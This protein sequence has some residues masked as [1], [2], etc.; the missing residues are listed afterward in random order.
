MHV[1]VCHRILQTTSHNLITFNS[2]K[3]QSSAN[4]RNMASK[5]IKLSDIF[6]SVHS[7]SVTL[8]LPLTTMVKY[9]SSSGNFITTSNKHFNE[10]ARD[11][12][13]VHVS[14]KY[15]NKIVNR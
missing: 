10:N 15:G 1:P 2:T 11:L 8:F 7:S 13:L 6:N 4:F 14:K 3:P 9:A 5:F 12:G